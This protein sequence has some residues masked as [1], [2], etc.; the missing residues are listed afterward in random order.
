[1]Q[2][3]Y[4]NKNLMNRDEKVLFLIF[5]EIQFAYSCRIYKRSHYSCGQL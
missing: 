1:M 4:N 2:I 3:C 5:V